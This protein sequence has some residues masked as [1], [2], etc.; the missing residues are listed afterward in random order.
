MM[1]ERHVIRKRINVCSV[2]RAGFII[3]HEYYSSE[4]PMMQQ[5]FIMEKEMT[6]RFGNDPFPHYRRIELFPEKVII[7]V[8][9]MH[10]IVVSFDLLF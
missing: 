10:L 8:S 9:C 3:A 1:E 5:L 7:I 6:R 4:S 2:E